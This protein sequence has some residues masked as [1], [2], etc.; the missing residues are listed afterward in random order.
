LLGSSRCIG[1]VRKILT[2]AQTKAATHKLTSDVLSS[3]AADVDSEI[4]VP[5]ATY[6]AKQAGHFGSNAKIIVG[7]EHFAKANPRCLPD[8]GWPS[9]SAARFVLLRN[10]LPET[11]QQV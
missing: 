4:P 9:P 11:E 2:K 10:L 5:N 1:N 6:A 8:D 3:E 7:R